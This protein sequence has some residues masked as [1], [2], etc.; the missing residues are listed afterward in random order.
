MKMQISSVPCQF[1]WPILIADSGCVFVIENIL[2]AQS[3]KLILS[4]FVFY[5]TVEPK[6]CLPKLKTSAF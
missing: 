6:Y 2:S 1:S 5:I 4:E 3:S